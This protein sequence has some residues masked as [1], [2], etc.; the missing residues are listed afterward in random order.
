MSGNALQLQV[1]SGS[2]CAVADLDENIFNFREQCQFLKMHSNLI[3]LYAGEL[4]SSIS[5]LIFAAS[6]MVLS[7]Y[8]AY[9]MV[10]MLGGIKN[11]STESRFK[12]IWLIIIEGSRRLFSCFSQDIVC[13]LIIL[14][15]LFLLTGING[16]VN[17]FSLPIEA[18]LVSQLL[19]ELR[20]LDQTTGDSTS[21]PMFITIPMEA[22]G[23]PTDTLDNAIEHTG[24]TFAHSRPSYM[25]HR[26]GTPQRPAIDS[27]ERNE[28]TQTRIDV[29]EAY[30]PSG[31]VIELRM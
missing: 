10:A 31:E 23:L 5:Q 9:G 6:V 26:R 29:S 18:I 8:K 13:G 25:I 15:T 14:Q 27:E 16:L 7:L 28:T 17:S 3:E 30:L 20:E 19:L 22:G 1:T 4:L 21:S 2:P 24:Q 11:A 12:L